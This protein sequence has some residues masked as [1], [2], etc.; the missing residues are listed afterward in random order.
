[1]PISSTAS[2]VS[3]AVI[4]AQYAVAVAKKAIDA[5]AAQG[6]TAVKMIEGAAPAPLKPGHRLSVVL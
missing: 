1:M 4:E 2:T 6:K 3:A 5:Q